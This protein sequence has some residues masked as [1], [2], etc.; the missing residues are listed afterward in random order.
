[1]EFHMRKFEKNKVMLL[2]ALIGLVNENLNFADVRE[3]I[4]SEVAELIAD[5]KDRKRLRRLKEMKKALDKFIS[6]TKSMEIEKKKVKEFYAD[7]I[8]NR[9]Q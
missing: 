4:D 7:S 6:E 9:D 1:M 5:L 8:S 2:K 3:E